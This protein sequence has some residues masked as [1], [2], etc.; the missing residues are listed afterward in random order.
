M[1]GELFTG[2]D[3]AWLRMDR[4]GNLAQIAGVM[5][6]DTPIDRA[7]LIE[8]VYERLLVYDRFRQRVREPLL[9]LG[10]PRWELDTHF[11]LNY[12]LP[13]VSLPAPGGQME[14][15]RLVGQLMSRPLERAHPLWRFFCVDNYQGG[16]ALVPVL[17]HCIADGL[18]LVQ[19]LLAMTDP[20]P[21]ARVFHAPAPADRAV[22]N[23]SGFA[24]FRPL[25]QLIDTTAGLARLATRE[26][27]LTI[28]EPARVTQAASLGALSVNAAS[29]LLLTSPDQKTIAY[30]PCGVEKRV[31][32]SSA[33]PLSDVIRVGR[34]LRGTVND[35]LLATATGALRRYM[36]QR[37]Q[38]TT[39]INIRAMV[40]FSIRAAKDLN[41]L[42]NQFGLVILSLPIGVSDPLQRL[43]VLK[44]RMD[45]IKDT[46]EALVAFGILSVM[47][48]TPRQIEKI[49]VDIFAGKVSAVMTN[50]PGPRRPIY[51]AGQRLN[52]LMFWVPRGGDV[53]LGLSILSYAGNAYVGIATDAGLMPDPEAIV[54]QYHAELADLLRLASPARS[55]LSPSKKPSANG[56]CHA[57][58]K[59]G[60]PCRNRAL[61][62]SQYCAVHTK[63][64]Q[65]SS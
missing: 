10:R 49:I 21:D 26:A 65:P 39:G 6:F 48:L 43:K 5:I 42:G 56:H 33:I 20:Q 18:A 27:L 25:T 47:G 64:L 50:V 53:G 52:S 13:Q 23:R 22:V 29:K 12:H 2:V 34:A 17:H 30:G 4:P 35:V 11:D 63:Q 32:W 62:N 61:P 9:G 46:P 15:Q 60:A 38:D 31:A 37:G 40:P 54:D 14:L 24:P 58:T 57:V 8:L 59:A 28:S 1:A 55:T 19:V 44:R 41:K 16:C 36:E 3:A 51:L 7:R 45:D